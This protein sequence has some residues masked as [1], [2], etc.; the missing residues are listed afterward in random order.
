MSERIE[1]VSVVHAPEGP[2]TGMHLAVYERMGK[3][4]LELKL[5]RNYSLANPVVELRASTPLQLLSLESLSAVV[6]N[7]GQELTAI[8]HE[9]AEDNTEA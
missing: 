1:K 2:V 5:T 4:I 3:T 6:W 8:A 9:W 7:L